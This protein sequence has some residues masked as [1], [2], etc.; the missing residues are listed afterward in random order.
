MHCRIPAIYHALKIWL[1]E[2]LLEMPT[3]RIAYWELHIIIAE[4]RF[5]PEYYFPVSLSERV[6]T[7]SLARPLTHSPHIAI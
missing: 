5:C 3:N 7:S 6:F 2:I 4:L 1:V